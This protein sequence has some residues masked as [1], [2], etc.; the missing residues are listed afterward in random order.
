MSGCRVSYSVDELRGGMDCDG[1]ADASNEYLARLWREHRERKGQEMA[2]KK[3]DAQRLAELQ[4]KERKLKVAIA[5]AK[6]NAAIKSD[7]NPGTVQEAWEGLGV[8]LK[9]FHGHNND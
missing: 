3:T 1:D 6:L 7:E 2:A 8:E 5:L 4:S 9:I